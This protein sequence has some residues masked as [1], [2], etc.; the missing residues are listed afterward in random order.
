MQARAFGNCDT[1]VFVQ[2]RGFGKTWITAVCC[3]AMA[4]LYPNTP[5]MVA[6]GTF[7]Q[8]SLVL[9]K[10]QAEFIQNE[11][12]YRELKVGAGRSPIR[13]VDTS[14]RVDLKNGSW[15]ECRTLGTMRGNR[16]KIVVIDEAP[17]VPRE[18]VDAVVGPLRNY[19]RTMMTQLGL[20][21]YESKIIFITR[22]AK[23]HYNFHK[24]NFTM[25][26]G[27]LERRPSFA[28]ITLFLR[29]NRFI[30]AKSE[31]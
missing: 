10:I 29:N 15:I 23:T 12:I 27:R 7:D 22:I 2:S 20:P 5:V 13:K 25:K 18:V 28:S 31:R 11:N 14:W 1:M 16:A 30:S 6:S 26:K 19:K 3:L 24:I 17:E 21:D 4:V 8:A 9:K